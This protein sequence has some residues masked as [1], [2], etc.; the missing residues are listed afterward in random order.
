MNGY[1]APRARVLQPNEPLVQVRAFEALTQPAPRRPAPKKLVVEA[2]VAK[3]EVE[4]ALVE[5]ELVKV[6]LVNTLVAPVRVF[7]EPVF[8]ESPPAKVLVPCPAPT[9]MAAAK[10]EVAEVE[11]AFITLNC[12]REANVLTANRLVVLA[13]VPVAETK[14]KFWKM[15]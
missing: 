10:V 7:I 8:A 12:P 5:V 3:K 4:V 11:V 14:V 9:V 6:P 15:D 13:L 2:R 1:A